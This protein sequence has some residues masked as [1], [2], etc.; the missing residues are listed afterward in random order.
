MS[1]KAPTQE[2]QQFIFDYLRSDIDQDLR[3]VGIDKLVEAQ[4]Y[5]I[6]ENG[7]E[8]TFE[9]ADFN[10]LVVSRHYGYTSESADLDLDLDPTAQ[11]MSVEYEVGLRRE[12][13]LG[14]QV[15]Q[16]SYTA[17]LVSRSIF[18]G[19]QEPVGLG[20]EMTPEQLEVVSISVARLRE[21]K[22]RAYLAFLTKSLTKIS[23]A[24]D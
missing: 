22:R 2:H 21:A 6:P 17:L 23:L 14:A 24:G 7:N 5:V 10:K 20:V 11:V 8:I 1:F 13:R 16:F 15:L 12:R 3:N 4:G 19:P 18:D 9:G